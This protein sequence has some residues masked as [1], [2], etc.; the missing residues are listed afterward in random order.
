MLESPEDWWSDGFEYRPGD[1]LHQSTDRLVVRAGKEQDA[2][3]REI[4]REDPVFG[5]D[6]FWSDGMVRISGRE[7]N[8][9]IDSPCFQQG[10]MSCLSCHQ[11]HQ[12]THDERP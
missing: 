9:L 12:D 10:E 6:H 8:G 7:Y 4:L 2:A 5:E 1:D 11:L 3:S